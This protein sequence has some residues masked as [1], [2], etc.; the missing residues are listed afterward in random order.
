MAV[1]CV[2]FAVLWVLIRV[3][4]QELHPFAIVV[5]R[6]LF[7]LL[8][9]LPMLAF[10]PGLLRRERLPAHI[11]RATSGLIATFATF[12]AVANAP[13]ANVMAINYT[14]PLFATLGAIIFLGER[15]RLVR[16]AALAA[17]F[18]GMLLVLRPGYTAI[19]PG[20]A[21]ALVSA[22]ATSFS[23]VAIKALTGIDDPRAVTVW[24]FLLMTP[25]SILV[26]LPVLSWPSPAIWGILVGIGA[27]AAAGQ[28]AL[29][30]AFALVDASAVL[31]YDFLRFA[32]ITVAGVA[33]FHERYDMLTLVG[34]SIILAAGIALALRE[35]QLA[36]AARLD[37]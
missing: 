30:R 23:I 1:S 11:R 10:T 26:A 32:L 31:P 20:I 36:R 16:G 15:V 8:W 13:M 24:S 9:L 7:G 4:S 2:A 17:G 29:A 3:A 18:I 22:L 25:F 27:S 35:R 28:L 37:N 14:A 19:T 12:Y 5:W 33:L 34:G 6:N 21:A